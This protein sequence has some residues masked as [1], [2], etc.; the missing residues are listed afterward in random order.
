MKEQFIEWNPTRKSQALLEHVNT[1][2]YKYSNQG[3]S[4]T[5]RQLY[6]QLVSRSVIP[7]RVEE[8]AKLGNVV[9]KGRLA[10]MIDWRMIEDRVRS[11]KSN[12]HWDNPG[13]ILRA[14]ANG[15]YL[16][17]WTNQDNYV[18]VWCEKDAVSNIIQPVCSRY[19]VT[20]M[21]NRGYSS[22]SAMYD[23]YFRFF[24]A[25][26]KGKKIKIIYLGDHDPS[27]MDMDRDIKNRMEIFLDNI[28]HEIGWDFPITRLALTMDQI[29]NYQ[30]P[31]NPAKVTD[32]RY[33]G[34]RELFGESSWELDALE[35]SVLSTLVDI[36]IQEYI[37]LNEFQRVAEKE[38]AQKNML[39]EIADN[40]NFDLEDDDEVED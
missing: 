40:T 16:D 3:Y 20:F 35:P 31:E 34:Y 15:Y 36:T 7:N 37:D 17:R 14:A 28:M 30:P 5:L 11:P 18:E 8:Y 21:A 25:H 10:G 39:K 22:Q 4:L 33:E 38:S 23:A 32:S 12:S 24:D 29:E 9:S 6:Y 13:Q 19:D 27:G 26:E 1:I 2:L